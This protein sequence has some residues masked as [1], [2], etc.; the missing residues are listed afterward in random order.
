MKKWVKVV[1]VDV[2]VMVKGEVRGC[3]DGF[4]SG[5]GIGK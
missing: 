3:V 5:E 1:G 2:L 4:L